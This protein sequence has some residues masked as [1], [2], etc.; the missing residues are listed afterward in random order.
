MRR[1]R[2]VIIAASDNFYQFLNAE[3]EKF[4]EQGY[5]KTGLKTNIS[6]FDT[7]DLLAKKLGWQ[8]QPSIRS[9]Y[10]KRKKR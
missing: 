1:V 5:K 2:K 10:V 8:R 6:L 4:I 7:T 3:R 9:I